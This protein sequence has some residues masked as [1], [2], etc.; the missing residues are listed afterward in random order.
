M[1][2]CGVFV[3]VVLGGGGADGSMQL[4]RGAD[5]AKDQ[6][7]FLASVPGAALEGVAFPLGALCKSDVRRLAAEAGLPSADRRSSAGICFIGALAAA[8]QPIP[9]RQTRQPGQC[10]A[11]G[12]TLS[13]CRLVRV[14][15]RGVG[16]DTQ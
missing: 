4:L 8:S 11:G 6:S 16:V 2:C 14:S 9:E 7:Y 5:P 15:G 13:V 3:V 10:S 12:A 1:S